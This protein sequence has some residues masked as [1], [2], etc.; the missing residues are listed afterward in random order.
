NPMKYLETKGFDITYLPVDESGRITVEQVK[1]AVRPDTILVSVMYGNNEVGSIMPVKEIGQ[2]LNNLDQ[3]IVFH[4]DAVQA[5]GAIDLDVEDLNVDLLSVSAHK[6]NGPK[7]IGFLYVREGL[8]LPSLLLGGEQEN[9]HRAGTENVPAILAFQKA[10]ELHQE[11][12]KDNYNH[13]LNLKQTFIELLDE[14][15]VEFSV[16]GSLE[17]SLPH[18]LSLCIPSMRSD[19]LLIQMDLRG[20]ALS[21]GSACTAGTLEPSHVLTAMFSE[22]AVEIDH[23]L[24]FSFGTQTTVDEIKRTVDILKEV[25]EK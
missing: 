2:Y 12:L 24:R 6:M 3:E 1:E 4:T 9:K 16:N 25:T 19:M 21:A 18:V 13:L 14:S 22:D 10:I 7:G 11:N 8:N 20:V 23:T 5:Y 15:G 17:H